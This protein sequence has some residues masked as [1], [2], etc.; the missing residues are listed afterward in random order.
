MAMSK[1]RVRYL[2]ADEVGLGKT[3]EAGGLSCGAKT[4]RVSQKGPHSCS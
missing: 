1:D 4:K 3:I 2:L